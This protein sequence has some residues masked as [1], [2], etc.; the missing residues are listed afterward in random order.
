VQEAELIDAGTTVMEKAPPR[1]LIRYRP[2]AVLASRRAEPSAMES[3]SACS[4]LGVP[5]GDG[6]AQVSAGAAS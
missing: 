4:I 2:P 1:R 3:I 5:V 6:D